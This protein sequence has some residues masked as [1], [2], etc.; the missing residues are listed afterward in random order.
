MT[1]ISD[2]LPVAHLDQHLIIVVKPAGMLS[3][4][5]RSA[6]KQDCLSGR[7]QAYFPELRIVHR[8]DRDT[9]GIMLLAR[10]SNV[11]RQLAQMFESRGVHKEYVADVHGQ[12][13]DD[14]GEIDEPI[15]RVT[16][17]S[18]PPRYHI[19]RQR[20]KPA[21]TTWRVLSRDTDRTRVL[22]KPKTGR[23]HQLRVHC[24]QLGHP[25]IGDPIYGRPDRR[26]YLHASRLSFKHPGTGD[27]LDVSVPI[28]F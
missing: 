4:P 7:L 18:L 25:I 9:S 15:A 21:L 27:R 5:G 2:E 19:D 28:P 3:V 6:D 22:L 17:C 13:Q 23:S 1:G 26:M 8:L 20:G 16:G 10:S 11:Q 12:L 24:H 14:T